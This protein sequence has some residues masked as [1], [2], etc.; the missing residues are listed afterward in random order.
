M[1]VAVVPHGIDPTATC[2]SSGSDP[3]P[4]PPYIRT[5]KSF[6]FLFHGGTLWRKGLDVLIDAY[7][8]T[9]TSKD[10]VTLIV[11]STYGDPSIQQ[12][13]DDALQRVGPEGPEVKTL[14]MRLSNEEVKTLYAS[15]D[16]YA[17]PAR[18]EGFGI[19]IAEA[20]L[21]GLPVITTDVGG[22]MDFTF[23]STVYLVESSIEV[24]DKE[25]CRLVAC[26]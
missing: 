24:C 22:H 4:L 14:S 20:M 19:T 7:L 1:Q 3:K 13:L 11:A 18:G 15:A 16:V 2:G 5:E 17:H 12:Y 6:K 8:S 23:N 9:F 21:C 25:P 26:S 10:D